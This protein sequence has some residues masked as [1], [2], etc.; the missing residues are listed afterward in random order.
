VAPILGAMASAYLGAGSAESVKGKWD[1]KV[2][3]LR[4]A[5]FPARCWHRGQLK[6]HNSPYCRMLCQWRVPSPIFLTLAWR[7]VRLSVPFSLRC[8][9]IIET[10]KVAKNLSQDVFIGLLSARLG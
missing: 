6:L 3:H 4:E 7:S 9:G 10:M 2:E 8:G 1:T 5:L